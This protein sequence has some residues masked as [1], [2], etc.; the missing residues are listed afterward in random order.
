MKFET[1]AESWRSLYDALDLSGTHPTQQREMKRAFY[2]GYMASFG[3]MVE[4]TEN[5]TEEVASRCLDALSVE[6]DLWCEENERI[7]NEI[8]R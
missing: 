3:Q 6:L 8:S 4:I 5:N 1:I 2:A 7:A